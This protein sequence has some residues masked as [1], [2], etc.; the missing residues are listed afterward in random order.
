ML[1]R[2]MSGESRLSETGN[3][4]SGRPLSYRFMVPLS[5]FGAALSIAS[6]WRAD[7]GFGSSSTRGTVRDV[8]APSRMSRRPVFEIGMPKEGFTLA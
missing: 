6:P 2:D 3:N 4:G 5:V 8:C 7:C 1:R